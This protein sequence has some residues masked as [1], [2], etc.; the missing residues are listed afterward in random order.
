MHCHHIGHAAEQRNRGEIS[1]GIVAGFFVE[2][3]AKHQPRRRDQQG[4][5]V[6]RRFRDELIADVAARAQTRINHK[7]LS[8]G[9]G[10]FGRKPACHQVGAAGAKRDHDAHGFGGVGGLHR[11]RG[12]LAA[13]E[14]GGEGA[15]NRSKSH[16]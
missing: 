5:A 8:E 13:Q 11:L 7:G 15:N 10:E 1:N 3:G 9:F 16:D 12:C 2:K 14:R 6:G 4:V